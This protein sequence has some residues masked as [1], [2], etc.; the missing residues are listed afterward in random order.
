M[1]IVTI[2][3]DQ[4]QF[5]RAEDWT[6]PKVLP[7]DPSLSSGRSAAFLSMNHTFVQPGHLYAQSNFSSGRNCELHV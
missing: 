6:N 4:L 2:Q 1:D 5:S 3:A 7:P